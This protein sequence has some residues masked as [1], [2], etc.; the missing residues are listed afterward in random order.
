MP[1]LAT[2]NQQINS[3]M[4]HTHE[5]AYYRDLIA[6]IQE[7][8]QDHIP[9][10][11]QTAY[12]N[13]HLEVGHIPHNSYASTRFRVY[14]NTAK[15]VVQMFPRHSSVSWVKL[16]WWLSAHG[17]DYD[18]MAPTAVI[19]FADKITR[20]HDRD[21][22]P[23]DLHMGRTLMQHVEDVLQQLLG[24]NISDLHQ[25]ATGFDL[26]A[27]YHADWQLRGV[28]LT[29]CIQNQ[30]RGVFGALYGMAADYPHTF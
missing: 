25:D 13:N 23:D 10:W 26:V 27:A 16:I 14:N 15:F 30:L 20:E 7:N 18:L 19:K 17:A 22:N 9:E 3:H 11:L 5:P 21:P 2:V 8:T 1:P 12:A 29:A 28:S 4:T 6:H 24:C